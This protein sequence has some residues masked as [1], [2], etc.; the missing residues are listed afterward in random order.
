MGGAEA[1]RRGS[2]GSW[3]LC[4]LCRRV[5]SLQA[6]A[7]VCAEG[8]QADVQAGVQRGD[9]ARRT[10]VREEEEEAGAEEHGEAAEEEDPAR[11]VD[12]PRVLLVVGLLLRRLEADGAVPVWSSAA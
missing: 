12:A 7:G 9:A 3:L 1:W 2:P 4:R 6:S 5:P 8:V 10:V 11:G